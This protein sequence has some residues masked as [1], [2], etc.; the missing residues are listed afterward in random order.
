MALAYKVYNNGKKIT[1]D[2]SYIKH[3]PDVFEVDENGKAFPF[4]KLT[5]KFLKDNGKDLQLVL[6]NFYNDL[7]DVD[8]ILGQ[9][10]MLADIDIIRRESI[11]LNMWFNKFRPLFLKK[12]ILDTMK[13]FKNLHPDKSASLDNIYKFLK[14]K[15]MKNHHNALMDCKNTFSCF[16]VMCANEKYLFENERMKFNEDVLDDFTKIK[17]QCSLCSNK[18]SEFDNCYK[19]KNNEFINDQIIYKL[20]NN[21]FLKRNR[22]IC[23][24]CFSNLE[25]SIHNKENLLIK[26]TKLKNIVE[27][28]NNFFEI[29]GNEKTSVYLKV[30]FKDKQK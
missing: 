5:N 28:T 3:N 23:K 17:K 13:T 16:K 14:N 29:I 25:L 19:F 10:I 8:I 21:N 12:Q 22:I 24:K 27:I 6:E 26:I 9:N 30:D 4:H 20:I 11:G 15:E 7:K 2:I 18:I 1:E